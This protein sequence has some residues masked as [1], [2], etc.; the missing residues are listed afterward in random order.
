MNIALLPMLLLL[1]ACIWHGEAHAA[2]LHL[3]WIANSSNDDGFEIERKIGEDG[4]FVQIAIQGVNLN[5]YTDDNLTPGT[6]YC[7]RVR[8]FNA[9]GKSGYSNEACAT[10][11]TIMATLE[12][13]ENGQSVSGLAVIRGWGFDT[14]GGG[15]ISGV[16]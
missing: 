7:Y 2:Q 8:A 14:Q 10:T 5:L 16:D 3:S 4:T 6:A 15:R 11:S 12:S 1:I 9:F 13:P